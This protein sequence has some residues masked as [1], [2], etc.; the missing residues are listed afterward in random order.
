MKDWIFFILTIVLLFAVCSGVEYK[1]KHYGFDLSCS[2]GVVI[3]NG[4]PVK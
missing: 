2:R 4:D 1:G 3:E